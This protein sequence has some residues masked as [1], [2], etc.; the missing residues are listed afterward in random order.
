M[1]HHLQKR[2]RRS[3]VSSQKVIQS[4]ESCNFL[5]ERWRR[6]VDCR[7]QVGG[8]KFDNLAWILLPCFCRYNQTRSNITQ[9]SYRSLFVKTIKQEFNKLIPNQGIFVTSTPSN[10]GSGSEISRNPNNPASGDGKYKY[11]NKSP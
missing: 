6:T 7:K 9:D 5:W 8:N 1:S 4:S 3:E 11:N 10:G 2:Q